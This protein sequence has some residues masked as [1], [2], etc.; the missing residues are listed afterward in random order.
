MNGPS[1]ADRLDR[2]VF[3][4]AG[5]RYVVW[6]EGIN[7]LGTCLASADQVIKG[8]KEVVERLHSKKGKSDRRD[9]RVELR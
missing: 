3:G 4:V 7:D 6:L 5:L 1:A 9:D 8:F 2:D